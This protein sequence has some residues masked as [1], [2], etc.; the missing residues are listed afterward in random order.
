LVDHLPELRGVVH[1]AGLRRDGLEPDE[2]SIE[3]VLA[4]KVRGA[5]NLHEATIDR[6]LDFFILVSSAA[7]T[8]GSPGQAAYGAANAALDGLAAER[9]RLGLP[10][11]SVA[12]GPWKDSAMV[13]GLSETQQ[14]AWVNRGV[15][16]LNPGDALEDLGAIVDC[17]ESHVLY[18]DADWD[19]LVR[20][21]GDHRPEFLDGMVSEQAPS[22]AEQITVWAELP[23]KEA[24]AQIADILRKEVAAVLALDRPFASRTPFFDLG[25]DSLTALELRN[26]LQA[27][28]GTIV[29]ATLLF[30]CPSLEP[31]SAWMLKQ[32]AA[33]PAENQEPSESDLE[34]MLTAKLEGLEARGLR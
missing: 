16:P 14:D 29:P 34:R 1:A 2:Q 7:G 30:D 9:K 23:P 8:L 20:M 4:A 6:P 3:D 32:V 11:V 17:G 10:A 22:Q 28:F 15:R 27:R 5:W 31:L 24:R 21:W 33:G 19:I 13:A 26:R 25:M 12:W 18:L